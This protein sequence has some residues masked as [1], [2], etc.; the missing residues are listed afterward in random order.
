MSPPEALQLLTHPYLKRLGGNRLDVLD[1]GAPTRVAR[2]DILTHIGNGA[3]A[4][5]ED[6]EVEVLHHV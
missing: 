4:N 2:D 5:T 1:H 6:D 3:D